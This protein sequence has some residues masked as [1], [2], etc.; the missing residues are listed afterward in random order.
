[1]IQKIMPKIGTHAHLNRQILKTGSLVAISGLAV[2]AGSSM[3]NWSEPH[4]E[5]TE[6]VIPGGLNLREKAYYLLKGK[7]PPSVYERW[8]PKANN[9]TPH[10]GD[11]TV[12]V[13]IADRYVGDI[14]KGPEGIEISDESLQVN[15]GDI[16]DDILAGIDN[17][18]GVVDTGDSEISTLEIWKHLAGFQ[19]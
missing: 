5:P 12:T 18:T 10:E 14:V 3:S 13:N 4:F 17:G 19:D 6:M 2:L 11:Q 15:D 16:T 1:M 9:Y 8:F 7:M